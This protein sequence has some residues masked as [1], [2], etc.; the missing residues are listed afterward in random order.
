MWLVLASRHDTA[1]L[2][3]ASRLRARLGSVK[4]LSPELLFRAARWEHRLGMAEH[5]ACT[6]KLTLADGSIVDDSNV[7]GVLNR[8]ACL[9]DD[10]FAGGLE[11]DRAYARQEATALLMSWLASL[12]CPVLNRPSGRGL[13]GWWGQ[14]FEWAVVAAR[15]GLP[16]ARTEEVG[17][18]RDLGEGATPLDDAAVGAAASVDPPWR[19]SER[20][21]AHGASAGGLML[22]VGERTRWCGP[23]RPPEDAASWA[24]ACRRLATSVGC[25]LLGVH[26]AAVGRGHVFAGASALPDLR[27][28][29]EHVVDDLMEALGARPSASVPP[30][31]AEAVMPATA[32]TGG[33]S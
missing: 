6:F 26:L 5:A 8:I 30:A 31:M 17:R 12:P 21:A 27:P 23:C 28:G 15:C 13:A 14:P 20:D 4:V 24:A 3:A 25:G 2:W 1:A 9:P 33:W 32:I 10:L 11:S 7:R 29:G 22:V 19:S 18:D 16:V